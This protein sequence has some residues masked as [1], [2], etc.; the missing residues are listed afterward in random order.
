MKERSMFLAMCCFIGLGIC[1][2]VYKYGP[3]KFQSAP[4]GWTPSATQ[5]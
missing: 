2:L 3:I 1:L 5:K 4:P